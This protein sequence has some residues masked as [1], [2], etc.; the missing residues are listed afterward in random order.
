M[1]AFGI[2]TM[3]VQITNVEMQ[4]TMLGGSLAYPACRQK[5]IRVS[6]KGRWP[7]AVPSL[8]RWLKAASL[9]DGR[10]EAG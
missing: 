3:V 6:T 5:S 1:V 7:E 9:M 8:W 10:L 4:I 2:A